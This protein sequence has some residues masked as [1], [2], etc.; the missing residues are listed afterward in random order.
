MTKDAAVAVYVDKDEW[1]AVEVHWLYRSWKHSQSNTR[2]DLVIFYNPMVE[3]SK[4]PEDD[5][6][7]LVPLAPIWLKE[8]LWIDYPRINSTWFLTS[9]AAKETLSKY[10]YTFRTDADGFLTKNFVDFRPRLATFGVNVYASVDQSVGR[11]INKLCEQYNIK[12]HFMNSDCHMMA[13]TKHAINYAHKQYEIA[14]R[15]K[16]EEFN[17]GHGAWPGWYEYI[18]NMYSAN[19]A[20]NAYFRG[21]YMLGGLGCMSMSL[22]PI[23]STDFHI[24]A[25]HTTQHFSKIKWRDG[26]YDVLDFDVLD[27]NIISSYCIKL[28]GKR[29]EA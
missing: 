22:D 28:A 18:I 11:K 26:Y 8:R 15:L 25:F 21:G 23:G 1:G 29:G 13:H 20:A 6:V 19:I 7:I 5:G 10:Q 3:K 2:S 9:D 27:E 24:H 17:D 4:L 12:Q 16:L 14:K